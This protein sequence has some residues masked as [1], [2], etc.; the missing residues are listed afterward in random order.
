MGIVHTLEIFFP[1]KE[2]KKKEKKGF[3][4]LKVALEDILNMKIQI[5]KIFFTIQGIKGKV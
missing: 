5:W 1:P 4:H 3:P 2:K